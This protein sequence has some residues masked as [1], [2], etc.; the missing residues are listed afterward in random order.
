MPKKSSC[1]DC[2]EYPV[3][4]LAQKALAVM[5]TATAAVFGPVDRAARGVAPLFA[6]IPFDRVAL[7]VYRALATLHIGKLLTDAD[8]RNAERTRLLWD[9]AKRKGITMW[10]F[11]PLDDPSGISFFVAEKDGAVRAFE[12]LPR[13]RDMGPSRSINW[14]DNK[15]VLKKKFVP[16]GIPMARGR[17]CFTFGAARR[18]MREVGAPLITKPNLG[19]RSRHSTVHIMTEDELRRGFRI[20]K[21]LSPWVIVEQELQGFVFRILLVDGEPVGVVRREPPFV[22]GDGVHTIRELVTEEN[23]NP[24]RHTEL[25]HEIPMDD[26]VIKELA[27][28][29]LTL[30]S[31]PAKGAMQILSTH[32]SR[33]YGGS[34]TNMTDVAHPD[35]MT[36]FRK[37]GTVLGDP[38]VGVDFIIK[39][40][41]RSWR[42][43]AP[44]GVIECNSLPNTDL[45]HEVLYGKGFDASGLLFDL[46][47][48]PGGNGS[49]ASRG[50]AARGGHGDRADGSDPVPQES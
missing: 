48:P 11:Q 33:F 44:C 47:F 10:Q 16:A 40:M 45:H 7:P 17:S 2:G 30:D 8:P 15:A 13:P 28:Q 4:H 9:A 26:D 14:M 35:N 21:Q 34:T 37:I 50:I 24:R 39:D 36:L 49:G 3:N 23:K 42:E 5:D 6:K 38:L 1:A 12:G 19:S 25:F 20:A 18:I 27:H 31:V 22:T 32:A 43:Q 46:A 41:T 29:G